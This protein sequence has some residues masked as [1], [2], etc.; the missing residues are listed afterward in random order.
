MLDHGSLFISKNKSK[1]NVDGKWWRRVNMV[2]ILCAHVSKWKTK[3]CW[4]VPG[5]G[6]ER[7][8]KENGGGGKFKCNILDIL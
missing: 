4:T 7:K 5:M 6:V 1:N 3:T 8:M 2:Q